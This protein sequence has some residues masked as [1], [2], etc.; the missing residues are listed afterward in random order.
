MYGNP[1]ALDALDAL[2]AREAR[3]ASV[4]FNGDFQWFDR[5]PGP[6][7]EVSERVFKHRAI[8]GNVE[9][10]FSAVDAAAGCGCAYPDGVGDEVVERSN[11][12][13]SAL[14]L[15]ARQFPDLAQ[16]I[17]ELPMNLVAQVGNARIAIVHGDGT[18]LAG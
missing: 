5:E 3:P 4:V 15:T 11:T 14:R 17:A 16:R 8:R 6:F 12:L 13:E 2:L 18:S 1:L 7:R 9:T 10:E